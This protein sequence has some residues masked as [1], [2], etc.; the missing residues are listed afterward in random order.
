MQEHTHTHKTWKERERAH[1]YLYENMVEE[2]IKD[3]RLEECRY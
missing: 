3:I 1:L 2:K